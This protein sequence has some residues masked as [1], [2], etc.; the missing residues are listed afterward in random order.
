MPRLPDWQ[1]VGQPRIA[2]SGRPVASIA[3]DAVGEG[4]R[5]LGG[6]LGRVGARIQKSV[7]EENAADAKVNSAQA[8]AY[9]LRKNAEY[10]DKIKNDPDSYESWD[11]DYKAHSQK[12]L[13]EAGALIKDADTRRLWTAQRSGTVER[14]NEQ[15]KKQAWST[16]RDKYLAFNQTAMDDFLKKALD[17]ATPEPDKV[18]Y[19]DTAKGIINDARQRGYVSDVQAKEWQDRWLNGYVVNRIQMMPPQQR[20][21]E[22]SGGLA[23]G[24]NASEKSVY[25]FFTSKG[26]L[27]HQA[28]A[29]VG[30]LVQESRLNTGARNP[31][32]GRDGSDSIGLGQW[33]GKRAQALKA[34]AA[35]RGKPVTDRDTQL[36]FVWR[37]LNGSESRTLAR[38][39]AARNVDEATAAFIG[40]ERPKGWSEANPRGGHGWDNRLKHAQRVLGGPSELAK[41]LPPEQQQKVIQS[42]MREL[43]VARKQDAFRVNSLAQD[44]LQA[45]S[46]SGQGLP[47][48]RFNYDIAAQ[49]LGPERAKM[50]QMEADRRQ[51][52]YDATAGMA[53]QP[54]DE[55]L[56]RVASLRPNAGS[57]QRPDAA[58]EDDA[59]APAKKGY[60]GYAADMDAYD[61]A[62]KKAQAFIEARRKDPAL[63]VDNFENVQAARNAKQYET[64]GGLQ[65]MT[66]SS[67]QELVRQ[68]LVAQQTLGIENPMT[69]TKP[70]ADVIAR[71]LRMIG[72]DNREGM[73]KFLDS[74]Q[75][76]YGDYADD[77][78]AATLQHARVSAELSRFA[79]SLLMGL[80]R[81]AIPS[82]YQANVLYSLQDM[83]QLD[84][85]MG[86]M[87]GDGS[88]TARGNSD[89]PP[90]FQY[91]GSLG[92]MMLRQQAAPN[93]PQKPAAPPAQGDMN[94]QAVGDF[95]RYIA[96]QMTLDELY[97][98]YPKEQVDAV[99]KEIQ[100]RPMRGAK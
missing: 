99:V 55:I 97:Q 35:E 98:L 17:P 66:P 44:H 62:R 3:T 67:A 28:A 2:E 8:D 71:Q 7:D 84:R 96:G 58:V 65:V 15:V 42:S 88:G 4:M 75:R 48:E 74:L 94:M 18:M 59:T 53:T 23:K 14:W 11:K 22:I 29:I 34:F 51:K 26:L 25:D 90:G 47:A 5:S 56:R 41:M 64:I 78:L 37:E 73:T 45:I 70:E 77:V 60:E 30:N 72:P 89:L 9:L 43:D 40:Y 68:R 31:G 16:G 92:G 85:A 27:P 57:Q 19:I 24:A 10:Q 50:I 49:A 69:I 79:S 1:A 12:A 54:D 100:Q 76:T 83:D 87:F 36:E 93:A 80:Q 52:V 82:A 61:K 91:T 20:I 38:L 6:S 13:S 63:A 46:D 33:N 39:K 81:G 32:D 95:K 21:A 86:G